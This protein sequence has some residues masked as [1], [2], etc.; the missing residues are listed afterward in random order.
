MPTP[1]NCFTNGILFY[2]I[3]RD[4]KIE[5]SKFDFDIRTLCSGKRPM[6]SIVKRFCA[7]VSNLCD[8]YA[9][10][11]FCTLFVRITAMTRM[12]PRRPTARTMEQRIKDVVATYSVD[13]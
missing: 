5:P 6:A 8:L 11:K 7:N 1:V 4:D 2:S 9:T 13:A 12:F 10:S 3:S